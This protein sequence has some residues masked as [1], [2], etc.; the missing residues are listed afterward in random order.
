MSTVGTILLD[1][2]RESNLIAAGAQLTAVQVDESLRELRRI[3]MAAV[4]TSV[5]NRLFDWPIGIDNNNELTGWSQTKWS[6]PVINA[7][8]IVNTTQ[9]QE[10]F[11]PL[12][13]CDG[14]RIAV[15]DPEEKL[16]SAP[17][18]LNG[19]GRVIGNGTATQLVLNNPGEALVLFY[20]AD[21]GKWVTLAPLSNDTSEEFPFPEEFDTYFI[22]KLAMRINPRYG[23]QMS[24]DTVAAMLLAE[25]NI[26]ARY[27]QRQRV[28][29]ELGVLYLSEQ[30]YDYDYDYLIS[31]GRVV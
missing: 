18:T 6:R 31:R 15:V 19:N 12:D 10:V 23:R 8:L 20:R 28:P 3:V 13:P 9:P 1:A 24:Q 21:L 25:R 30:V 7:R 26:R 16:G 17:L 29:T 5:G 2:H 4:G 11:L 14:A 22:T 27:R